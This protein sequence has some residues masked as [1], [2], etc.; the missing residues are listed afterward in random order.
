MK[1]KKLTLVLFTCFATQLG[2]QTNVWTPDN[3][4]GTFTNPIMWGD[5]PDPDVI[6][7]GDY[8]YMVSTSM[9]YV[10]GCPIVRSKD[11][12]NW[13]MVG[14]AVDRYD[15]D[16]KY[17]LDGGNLYLNGSWAATIRHHNDKFYVGFC[18][19]YGWGRETGHYSMCIAD[20]PEG[21]WE[22]VIFPEYLYDPGLL[23]DDNGKVYVIHG[24]HKLYAT[25]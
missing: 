9:H 12:V 5:W 22:R 3:G 20:K 23:F 4:N 25:E 19:P 14:Y 7:V 13:E 8:F 10:P 24:Q 21:P 16:P 17:N 18:T 6:R 15:E 2:A 11:L 1:L